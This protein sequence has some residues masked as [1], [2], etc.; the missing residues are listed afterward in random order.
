MHNFVIATDSCCD[1][2]ASMAE[3]MGLSLVLLNVLA[4]GKT[5]TNHP[6]WRDIS[7]KDFYDL[8]RA[9][10]TASTSAPSIGDFIAKPFG[11]IKA[12]AVADEYGLFFHIGTKLLH[13]IEKSR[14]RCV[15]TSCLEHVDQAALVI[16]VENR[17]NVEHRAE[18]SSNTADASASL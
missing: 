17:L 9:E 11:V 3:E 6:D 5:Y 12:V 14:N 7:A 4:D 15:A 1:L 8:M 10:K 13:F 18:S 2:P 16:Y